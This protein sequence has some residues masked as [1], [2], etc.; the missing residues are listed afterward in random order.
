MT[1]STYP[2]DA[3]HNTLETA[4]EQLIEAAQTAND[5]PTGTYTVPARNANGPAYTVEITTQ[6]STDENQMTANRVSYC[7]ECGWRA[8][9]ADYS[10]QEV[11]SRAV[12][13][14][15]ETGHDIESDR[16]DGPATDNTTP[17]V[18]NIHDERPERSSRPTEQQTRDDS[19]EP[20]S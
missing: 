10:S 15:V 7:C 5:D 12:Q 6:P 17:R 19:I 2:A 13:H 1:E 9:T 20:E 14:A 16:R 4:L 8:S 3:D 11:S 18:P